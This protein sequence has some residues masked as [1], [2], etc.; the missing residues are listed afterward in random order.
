MATPPRSRLRA[1][2]S[3]SMATPS[4]RQR[5]LECSGVPRC[6]PRCPFSGQG[7]RCCSLECIGVGTWV[8]PCSVPVWRPAQEPNLFRHLLRPASLPF[9]RCVEH[10]P[11]FS[12]AVSTGR[13]CGTCWH[14]VRVAAVLIVPSTA[15]SMQE[16][17]AWHGILRSAACDC[18]DSL[19]LAAGRVVGC[20][21]DASH[22]C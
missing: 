11:H 15:G 18:G 22:A 12:E 7:C 9:P 10:S 19:F 2:C 14:T 20:S 3:W 8:H 4:V 16:H 5:G 1:S 13:V 17:M 6:A 21:R